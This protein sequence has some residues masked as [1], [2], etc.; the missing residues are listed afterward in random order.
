MP[1]IKALSVS[2]NEEHHVKPFP[3][4]KPVAIFVG[5]Y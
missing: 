3:K 1:L 4:S 5:S 2:S